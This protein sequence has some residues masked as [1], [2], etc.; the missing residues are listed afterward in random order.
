M[1]VVG[2]HARDV[3][4]YKGKK[5]CI[6]REREN[7]D[8]LVTALVRSLMRGALAGA[9]VFFFQRAAEQHGLRV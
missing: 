9:F 1:A 5:Y 6:A 2:R 7:D 8:S 3:P 4:G